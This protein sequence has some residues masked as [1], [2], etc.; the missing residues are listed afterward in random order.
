MH[1]DID[2]MISYWMLPQQDIPFGQLDKC[3]KSSDTLLLLLL[4][5]LSTEN[6]PFIPQPQKQLFFLNLEIK[7]T[8][9]QML[10]LN[11]D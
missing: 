7:Q 5:S 3:F 10:T 2:M 4:S 11:L 6:I 8:N 1:F 9:I